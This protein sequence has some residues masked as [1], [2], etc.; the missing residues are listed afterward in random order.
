MCQF[1]LTLFPSEMGR[2]HGGPIEI[3]SILCISQRHGVDLK[4]SK[5]NQKTDHVWIKI[6]ALILFK[7]LGLSLFEGLLLYIRSRVM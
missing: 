7:L 4:S 2:G 6:M 3:L 5:C 1:S